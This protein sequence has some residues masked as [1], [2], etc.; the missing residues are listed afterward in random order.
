MKEMEITKNDYYLNLS[1]AT[2]A[3]RLLHTSRQRVYLLIQDDKLKGFKD[4]T[5]KYL[6]FTSSIADYTKNCYETYSTSTC[7][8][9][10]GVIY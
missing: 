10:E 8:S 2:Q 5:G 6:I 1:T 3:A 4:D 9:V 7:N